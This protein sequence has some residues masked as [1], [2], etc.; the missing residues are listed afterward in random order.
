MSLTPW[1]Y[2]VS[3][4]EVASDTPLF[5]L[6]TC[7]SQ[8]GLVDVAV[9]FAGLG[10]IGQT[11]FGWVGGNTGDCVDLVISPTLRFRI[12]NG[13]SIIVDAQPDVSAAQIATYLFG[14]AFAALHY[15]RGRPPW[16]AGA[17]VTPAGAVAVAGMRGAGKSTTVQALLRAGFAFL[18]DDQMVVCP[19]TG[20][21]EPGNPSLKLWRPSAGHFQIPVDPDSRVAEGLEK[22]HISLPC[23]TPRMAAPLSAICILVREAGAPLPSRT[24]LSPQEA[25]VALC[26]LA[27]H[28]PAAAAMGRQ[29][30]VFHAAAHLADRVPVFVVRRPDDLSRLGEVVDL[31]HGAAML[32]G[33]ARAGG[34]G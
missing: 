19:E 10:A 7:G 15:Q 4:L 2:R 22:F 9:R 1:H 14:P 24:L 33:A 21:V 3:G 5:R 30:A 31:V 32:G 23:G 8:D 13:S 28:L 20:R 27:H 6:R 34:S 25:V 29:D 17:V 16:H 12:E 26:N 18:C 11:A